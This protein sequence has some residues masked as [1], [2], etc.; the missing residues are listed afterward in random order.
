MS[1]LASYRTVLEEFFAAGLHA[2]LSGF[3]RDNVARFTPPN[4]DAPDQ[5]SHGTPTRLNFSKPQ[6]AFRIELQSRPGST[7]GEGEVTI[8]SA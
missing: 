4:P 5:Q 1:E 7:A 3:V 8:L 2:L 6:S